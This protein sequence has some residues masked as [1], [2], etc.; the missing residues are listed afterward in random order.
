MLLGEAQVAMRAGMRLALA[1]GG[2]KT[3][4]EATTGEEAVRGALA[5][6]PDVCVLAVDL[7]GGGIRTAA[8]I[9]ELLPEQ[10]ILMMSGVHRDEDLFASLRAGASGYLLKSTSAE[11]LPY[12]VRGLLGGEGVL[13]RELAA[14]LIDEFRDRSVKRGLSIKVSGQLVALTERESEVLGHLR[15]GKATAAIARHLHISEVTVRRHASAIMQKLGTS[16]RRS[17]LELLEE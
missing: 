1:Q 8:R 17:M 16:D 11:R 10:R 4:F 14:R 2:L 13:P 5:H 3:V 7:P 9:R 6:C 15:A 12:A